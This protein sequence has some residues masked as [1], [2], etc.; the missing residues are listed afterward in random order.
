M[1]KLTDIEI[2]F[3]I[4]MIV[5]LLGFIAI[6]FIPAETISYCETEYWV[7]RRLGGDTNLYTSNVEQ[8][9][10]LA[11]G[12]RLYTKEKCQTKEVDGRSNWE[13]L[14]ERFN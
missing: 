9:R 6:L 1:K 7:D 4:V 11:G 8:A 14:T 13:H 12:G 5:G 3:P 2:F 10:E